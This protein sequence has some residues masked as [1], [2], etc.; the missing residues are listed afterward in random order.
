MCGL[1]NRSNL[2]LIGWVADFHSFTDAVKNGRSHALPFW[3]VSSTHTHMRLL[4][5]STDFERVSEAR[6]RLYVCCLASI[7]G[8]RAN[9]DLV[10][11]F[12]LPPEIALDC[13]YGTVAYC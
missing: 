5:G 7:E 10:S 9:L 13:H 2:H 6:H 12:S 11:K 4:S 8:K 3:T 1:T